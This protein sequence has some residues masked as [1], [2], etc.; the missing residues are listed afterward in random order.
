MVKVCIVGMRVREKLLIIVDTVFRKD[1]R[2][3]NCIL[4]EIY[5]NILNVYYWKMKKQ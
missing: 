1:V 4:M 3:D 2:F 5:I